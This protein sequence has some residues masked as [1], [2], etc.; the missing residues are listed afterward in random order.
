MSYWRMRRLR[1][2]LGRK[3]MTLQGMWQQAP[4][5]ADCVPEQGGLAAVRE[6]Y[7]IANLTGEEDLDSPRLFLDFLAAWQE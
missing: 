4:E 6:R 7:R 3:R 1:T 5:F 2:L